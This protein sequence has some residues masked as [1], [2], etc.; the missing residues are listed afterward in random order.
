MNQLVSKNISKLIIGYKKN[1]KQDINIEKKN[2]QN[3]VNIP[4][5]I[6]GSYNI[7]RKVVPDAFS[8]EIEGFVVNPKVISL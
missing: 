4:Y 6:Y 3:F 1:W 8:K 5:L 2:N 7:M